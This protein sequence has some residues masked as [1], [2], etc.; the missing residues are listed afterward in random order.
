MNEDNGL[1]DLTQVVT[2]YFRLNARQYGLKSKEVKAEYILNWG[3]FVNASFHITDGLHSLHLKL[4]DQE[5]SLNNLD[6][7]E[8]FHERLEKRY[9]A[10][11]MLDW[12]TLER[13]G[14]EGALFE[15]IEGSPARL[16]PGSALLRD[17]MR[18]VAALHADK[19]VADAL[20]KWDEEGWAELAAEDAEFEQPLPLLCADSLLNTYVDRFDSDLLTILNDLPPFVPLSTLDWMQGETRHL[21]GLA[22]DLPAFQERA[23]SPI[24]GD[25]WTNNILVDE[26]NHFF[27][28]DW[29][30][31]AL[32][33]PALDWSILLG[34]LW[35]A[36][37]AADFHVERLLPSEEWGV[38][39]AMRERLDVYLQASLL[40]EI[41]DSLAD[42]VEVGFAPQFRDEMRPVKQKVHEGAL[43]KYR[44]LYG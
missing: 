2:E 1:T 18:T 4:S 10:P 22:R 21:E 29:D 17:V 41:I 14:Y 44:Q 15:H 8:N 31:L 25:L 6:K 43:V 24:H 19:K 38:D 33:D 37:P 3:G 34:G 28:I 40:D 9:H 27:L 23:C 39:A 5:E 30:D 20:T 42:Y 11:R 26:K 36:D 13:A 12:V 32:G 16:Q 35:R 7:W